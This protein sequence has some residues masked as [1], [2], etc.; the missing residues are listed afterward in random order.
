M[1]RFAA[2]VSLVLFLTPALFGATRMTYDINGS[3]TAIEW[4]ASAFPMKYEIDARVA[5]VHPDA[6]AMVEK[7]FAA[8]AAVPG[9]NVQFAGQGVVNSVARRTADR[10]AVTITDDL[11]SGQGAVAYTSY[12][13]D[14]STG[15]M[16]DADITLDPSLF[17]GSLNAQMALQHEV[18][19]VLGLDHSAVL[20]SIMYP[21]VGDGDDPAEFEADDR[22]AIARM[23]PK[24]DP[25]LAGGTMTGRVIGDGGGIFAAQVVAVNEQGQPV[26]SVLTNE[27]GEFSL[28]T[29]PPGRYRLYAE[30]LDGPVETSALQGHWQTAS[31]DPFPTAFFSTEVQVESGNVYGNLVLTTAGSVRLNPRW[32]GVTP[33][34]RTDV[35]LAGAP[36]TVRPGQTVTISVAGDGFTSGMTKFEVL[37]PAFRQV[38]D[39]TWA[40]NYVSASFTVDPS[41]PGASSVVLV[42]DGSETAMLTGGLRV[43]RAGGGGRSRAVRH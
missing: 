18:G 11:L 1:L 4:P 9:A 30:P 33:E 32:I 35:S 13:Y 20:A 40:S 25:T 2:A 37:N 5:K 14:L 31:R 19:H 3:P 8:W 21:Y 27:A 17:D 22:I 38:S 10:V 42:T 39:F 15:E 16:I 28:S 12:S 41:A 26:A 36:A 6:T 7:A 29:M 43:Y 23:Y 34:G 24:S